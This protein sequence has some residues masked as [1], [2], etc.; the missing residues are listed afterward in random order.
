MSIASEISRLTA[1][2]NRLRQKLVSL[3]LGTSSSTLA[4]I[5]DA[6]EGVSSKGA[7][8]Y[9]P[10]TTNQ[11]IAAGQYL[12]GAQT[13]Q[14]DQN[15]IPANIA[16]GVSIFGVM[17]THSGGGGGDSKEDEIITRTISG[18]YVNDRI[19]SIGQAA[20]SSCS[21]L[22]TVSFPLVTSI[23]AY[24]FYSCTSLE[25]VSFPKATNIGAYAFSYCTS[26]KSV[27]FSKAI[28]IDMYAFAYC[29]KLTT[30]S[31]P[32]VTHINAYA[33]TACY[34]FENVSFPKVTSIYACAFRSC[35]NLISVSFPL[36]TYISGSV[37]AFCSKLT[38]VSFPKAT[39]IYN[40]AFMSCSR[41][42]SLYLSGSKVVV[43]SGTS[44]FYST[45][46]GGYSAT[47]GRYGSVYVPASLLASYKTATN[48]A[49]ISSRLVGH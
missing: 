9:T 19:T 39:S 22:T 1:L 46:I 37:F 8:T 44:V 13:V 20:F 34:S 35:Y 48:W 16:E 28:D 2:R 36:V 49:S 27:S 14:G 3:G 45:P 25:S 41:L 18:V 17:G 11:T 7:Q 21:K 38:T 10:T 33:F 47:A 42:I 26:L 32:S 5:T 4:D 30:V 40:Y 15:L 24:A 23:G 6:V 31:F 43:L 29:S 12:N